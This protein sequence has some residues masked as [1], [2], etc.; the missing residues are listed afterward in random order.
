[1]DNY[2][3][4]F[5][6]DLN[7]Y[8]ILKNSILE[9]SLSHSVILYGDKGIG[10]STFS[11]YFINHLFNNFNLNNIQKNNKHSNLIY[12]N[13][14]PN[15]K[16]INIEVD[17]KTK[18]YK[19]EISVDQIRKIDSFIYQSSINHLP[20]IILIENADKLNR[21]SSN[22][23]LK[24]LE[25]PRK[26]TFIILISHQISNLLPTIRSRCI[27]FKINKPNYDDFVKIIKTIDKDISN[28]NLLFMFDIS[29]GSPGLAAN[30]Y[31][32]EITYF[33]QNLKNILLKKYTLNKDIIEFASFIGKND[34][35]YFENFLYLLEFIFLNVIKINFGLSINKNF[36]SDISNIFYDISKNFNI[37]KCIE[38]NNYILKHKNDIYTF[39]IDKKIFSLNLFSE[40]SS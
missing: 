21:N 7:I 20:K 31:N 34:D 11:Y 24:I 33:F 37:K 5:L 39:N 1:M 12:S 29:K 22:A 6:G 30:L 38:I 4:F 32:K 3:K 36:K 35:I 18:K 14:H 15:L 2:N 26:N 9:K 27:K 25:E 17:I 13:S 10:K 23:L 40:L 8:E 16:I 28:E 19:K